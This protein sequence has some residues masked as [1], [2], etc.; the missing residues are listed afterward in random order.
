MRKIRI[1]YFQLEPTIGGIETFLINLYNKLNKKVFQL[2]FVANTT[3]IHSLPYLNELK[4]A[5]IFPISSFRNVFQYIRDINSI[6]NRGYDIVHFNKNSNANIIPLVLAKHNRNVGK[7]IVHSH[8]TNPSLNK[9]SLE[10]LHYLNRPYVSKIAN[11]KLACSSKAAEWLFSKNSINNVKIIK[12]GIDVKKYLFSDKK[13]YKIRKQYNISLNATVLGFVGRFSHQKNLPFLVDIFYDYQKLN[14][15]S[16][17]LL[18]GNG[19]QKNI[20]Q[21]KVNN[22]NI[23]DKVIFTGEKINVADYFCAMDIF[24]MP[25]Y[26][27]GLPIACVEAQASGLN[28]FISNT[29]SSEVKLLSSLKQFDIRKKPEEIAQYVFK[30]QS[31]LND[32]RYTRNEEVYNK[33]DISKTTVEVRNLYYKIMEKT[34][35]G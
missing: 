7:I 6:L 10:L 1:I 3:N 20:I 12:N 22:K 13:K 2:D 30:N 26:Y 35:N 29:I 17:L 16:Y 27:E 14:P 25:S 34:N 24:V 28:V 33:Y 31:L 21:Q 32:E 4:G 9:K 11:Y 18:I 15:D 19:A 8:N 23:K 5:N